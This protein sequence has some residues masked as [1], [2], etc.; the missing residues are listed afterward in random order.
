MNSHVTFSWIAICWIAMALIF[1]ASTHSLRAQSHLVVSSHVG[2]WEDPQ[3]HDNDKWAHPHKGLTAVEMVSLRKHVVEHSQVVS[4]Q[5]LDSPIDV[6]GDVELNFDL[7]DALAPRFGESTAAIAPNVRLGRLGK[8]AGTAY[9]YP[10]ETRPEGGTFVGFKFL[11]SW[12]Y[13]SETGFQKSVHRMIPMAAHAF[14]VSDYEFEP[15]RITMGY[16]AEGFCQCESE[17]SKSLRKKDELRSWEVI[18]DAPFNIDPREPFTDDVFALLRDLFTD[19]GNGSI[20]ALA[21]DAPLGI[22]P[23]NS[24]RITDSV[25]V[26][27]YSDVGDLIG[28]R[29][30]VF[31]TPKAGDEFG[32]IL[33]HEE[34]LSAL[35]TQK[36]YVV[37]DEYGERIGIENVHLAREAVD[38]SGLRFYE[39][40]TLCEGRACILKEVKFV[41]PLV[42]AHDDDETF[43]GQAPLN[44]AFDLRHLE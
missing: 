11:E 38:V 33:S 30:T 5:D 41:V 22:P 23:T 28:F 3:F 18:V 36:S 34:L 17:D 31:I 42:R 43:L 13:A 6:W 25:T 26:R 29:D 1:V 27:D 4:S 21:Y 8:D 39:T 19:V 7:P 12:S 14:T 35:S 2:F 16:A 10:T 20:P 24:E 32:S 44:V 15:W 40:W 9:Y 37:I